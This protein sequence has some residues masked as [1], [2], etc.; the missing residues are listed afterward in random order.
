MV[1]KWQYSPL[2]VRHN[3]ICLNRCP[4]VS[5]NA[6]DCHKYRREQHAFNSINNSFLLHYRH[7]YFLIRFEHPNVRLNHILD[8]CRSLSLSVVFGFLN[9]ISFLTILCLISMNIPP[10][11]SLVQQAMLTFVYLD[12]LQSSLW[13]PQ[14]LNID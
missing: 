12:M 1:F 4:K 10:L 14:L 9:D 11:V 3:M 7:Y 2:E 8:T 6:N 5:S 13:M